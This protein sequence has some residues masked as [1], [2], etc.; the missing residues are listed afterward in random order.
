M[1]SPNLSGPL[2]VL[3]KKIQHLEERIEFLES[4]ILKNITKHK[5]KKKK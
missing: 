3:K 5:T 2:E 1:L 4:L